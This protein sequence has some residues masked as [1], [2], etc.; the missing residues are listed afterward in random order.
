MLFSSLLSLSVSLS[1]L[2]CDNY[3]LLFSIVCLSVKGLG[4]VIV[5]NLVDVLGLF[6]TLLACLFGSLRVLLTLLFFLI[7]KKESISLLTLTEHLSLVR[8]VGALT[9]GITLFSILCLRSL[10]LDALRLFERRL[11]RLLLLCPVGIVALGIINVG[12]ND[13]L[14]SGNSLYGLNLLRLCSLTTTVERYESCG[15]CCLILLSVISLIVGRGGELLLCLGSDNGC[16]LLLGEVG[17][18]VSV[19]GFCCLIPRGLLSRLLGSL[20]FLLLLLECISQSLELL[21][22]CA[23]VSSCALARLVR[24]SRD[25]LALNGNLCRTGIV[26]GI[27]LYICICGGN[28]ADRRLFALA[29]SGNEQYYLFIGIRTGKRSGII[30]VIRTGGSLN[31]L[32]HDCVLRALIAFCTSLLFESLSLLGISSEQLLRLLDARVAPLCLEFLSELLSGLNSEYVLASLLTSSLL[33]SLCRLEQLLSLVYTGVFGL[34]FLL[35][36]YGLFRHCRL[37]RSELVLAHLYLLGSFRKSGLLL[38]LLFSFMLSEQSIGL[39]SLLSRGSVL[40]FLRALFCDGAA[41]GHGLKLGGIH[42]V[43]ELLC[44]KSVL[45]IVGGNVRLGHSAGKIKITVYSV[46]SGHSVGKIKICVNSHSAYYGHSSAHFG[47]LVCALQTHGIHAFIVVELT[48]G[49]LVLILMFFRPLFL[50]GL[51][52]I[53]LQIGGIHMNGRGHG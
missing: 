38:S 10:S 41:L 2:L 32:D 23:S 7:C 18:N 11:S 45:L 48:L 15:D 40:C 43:A 30:F 26:Y 42:I 12:V 20:I 27:C 44:H 19:Y 51:I 33:F 14:G 16:G 47:Q 22:L 4:K 34:L 25:L 37:E 53:V 35:S 9:L 46:R 6:E 8:L 36:L 28:N 50:H 3:R 5:D 52:C 24:I 13:L 21:A 49:S 1:L 29:V 39:L 31:S 17:L